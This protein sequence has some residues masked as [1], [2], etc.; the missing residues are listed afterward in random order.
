MMRKW[1]MPGLVTCAAWGFMASAMVLAAE[2]GA[3]GPG[4]ANPFYA[5][6]NGTG[7]GRVPPEEQAAML[8]ELGYAGIGFT[9]VRQIPEMLRTLD[10]H[11]LKMYSIYVSVCLTPTQGQPP[12]DP[13][14]KTAT[15]QLKGRNT[16]I[17]LPIAGGRPSSTD[18][19][20][21][22]VALVRE[23]A[24]LAEESGLRVALYPH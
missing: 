14:L 15:G 22:A 20:D 12:Y 19:D 10:A 2:D 16:L 4:F 1:M 6:D 9:G 23:I 13:G 7:G 3:A 24:D 21:R 17:L 5:F 8:K 11:G 18:L